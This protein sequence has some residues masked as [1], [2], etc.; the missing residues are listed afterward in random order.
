MNTSAS[1][2]HAVNLLCCGGDHT[3][4]LL[5]NGKVVGWGGD[6]S[7]RVASDSPE[8]CSTFKAPAS[9]VEVRLLQPLVAVT[10]GYGVSLGITARNE[11]AVWG[12]NAAGIGGRRDAIALRRRSC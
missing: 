5:A 12:A 8:Y 7:G 9:A 6:G 2:S 11:V 1:N 3:L 4:A 10:A